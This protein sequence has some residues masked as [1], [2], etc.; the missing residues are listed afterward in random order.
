MKARP[1]SHNINY[2]SNITQISKSSI[3]NSISRERLAQELFRK[4]IG[5]RK[6]VRN[7]YIRINFLNYLSATIIF[8]CLL[9]MII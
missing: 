4:L 7:E 6:K 2:Y 1:T 5:V 3:I 9:K 8:L